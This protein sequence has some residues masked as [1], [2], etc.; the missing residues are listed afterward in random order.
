[1]QCWWALQ[2]FPTR[3]A[4]RRSSA[5]LSAASSTRR[6]A[7]LGVL[8]LGS[9]SVSHPGPAALFSPVGRGRWHRR[10]PISAMKIAPFGSPQE[11]RGGCGRRSPSATEQGAKQQPKKKKKAKEQADTV[12]AQLEAVSSF[13]ESMWGFCRNLPCNRRKIC[14]ILASGW[15]RASP[16]GCSLKARERNFLE[17]T[18]SP[19]Q[20]W[21]RPAEAF[22]FSVQTRGQNQDTSAMHGLCFFTVQRAIFF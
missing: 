17:V 7:V 18:L 4:P 19:A 16:W 12:A 21:P 2:P 6:G 14:P 3:R 8:L 9:C 13:P 11:E 10:V 22:C 20:L 1:M 5:R 15:R